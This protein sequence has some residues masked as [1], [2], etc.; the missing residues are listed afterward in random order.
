M[1]DISHPPMEQ[2]QDLEYCIDSN[3]PWPETVLLAFQ[4]YILMLGTTVMIPSL[5]VPY[6]GGSNRDK[7]CVIQ[8]LLFVSGLNTL[9]QT[10]FG[11]RL[12]AVVGGSFAYV[13]PILYII[14]DSSLQRITDHHD[15]FIHTMRAIQGAL[16]VAS[17]I[18]I[19]AGYSQLWGLFSRFFSPLGMAPAIGLVG[20]GLFQRG[21]PMVG[22]C[23]EIGLPMLLLVIGVSQYL[24]HTKLLKDIPVFERFPLLICI[25]II[26]IYSIILTASGTY[27]NRPDPTQT[28]CRTDKA[29]II[30]TAPW[31]MFP[32]PLQWGPP[33]FSAGHAFAMMSSVLVSMAESTGAYVAASRLA[34]ATPPPAYVLSRGIG[35]QGIG[36]LLDGLYGTGTGST[37]SVEN[38]GLLGLTRV[39]SRRVV[40]ISAGF[41]IFFSILGKFGAVFASIPFPIFAALYCVLFGLVGAVGLSFLQFTNMNSMRNLII[42][43]LSLFLGISIPQYFN[44]YVTIQHGLVRTNAGWFNA[45]L[46]TVFASPPMVGLIVAVFLD[47]TID[48]VDSKKDRGMPWWVKFRTFKGDNRNEEFYTLP[49]NLN[50][51]FP[52]T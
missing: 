39:G 11:T 17:S 38:V 31:F 12:P 18:Q 28:S 16:I 8:T 32:Y 52:P 13:M 50:R 34:I 6:M 29:Y 49:F 43:G 40:Q 47:N 7:A 45:F 4:N 37:V 44:E 1:A 21:F 46:N 3:P 27:R 51:F 14:N 35:W 25:S 41:M 26:W 24:K 48:V 42:I 5:L 19:V 15:R 9:L 10:L 23:V 33:T 2:L 20:L 30:S 36:V 22:N